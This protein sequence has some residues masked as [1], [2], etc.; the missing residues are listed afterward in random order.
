MKTRFFIIF[1]AIIFL[2]ANLYAA[3]KPLID[4]A[5]KEVEAEIEKKK[6]AECNKIK[7]IYNRMQCG[8]KLMVAA[9]K[10]G[11]MRG[12]EE[13]CE[14]KY[15][16]LDFKALESLL[17]KLKTGQKTARQSLNVM[18][19]EDRQLGEI[20]KEDLETEIQWVESRLA[21]MQ[22]EGTHKIKKGLRYQ[23]LTSKKK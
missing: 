2:S 11:K 18:E 16:D 20:T 19:D 4:P 21:K 12:S 1:L 14:K 5:F 3:E 17:K 23:D 8:K 6:K 13:Y 15:T 10:E 7:N 22:R 9:R